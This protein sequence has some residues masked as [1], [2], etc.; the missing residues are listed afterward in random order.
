[1]SVEFW[2][3]NLTLIAGFVTFG[4]MISRT[5]RNLKKAMMECFDKLD[6]RFEQLVR[7][8]E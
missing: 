2:V 6:K 7:G 3:I 5:I 4:I 1:V 8:N